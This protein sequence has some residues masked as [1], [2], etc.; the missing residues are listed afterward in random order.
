M[1]NWEEYKGII[2]GMAFKFSPEK[3]ETEDWVGE[4]FVCFM[5][6]VEDEEKNGLICPFEAALSK[7][8]R[9]RFLNILEKRRTQSRTGEIISFAEL[10]DSLGKNPWKKIEKY[11]SLSKEMREVADVILNSPAEF[12]DLIRK[13]DFKT[14]LSKYLKRYKGWTSKEIKKFW[15]EFETKED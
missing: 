13:E 3:Q 9:Q 12:I 11:I 4:G 1:R 8:I 15:N 14:G 10:E 2:F 6:V 7:H 5:E